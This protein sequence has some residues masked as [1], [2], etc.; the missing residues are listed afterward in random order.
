MVSRWKQ[1]GSARGGGEGGARGSLCSFEKSWNFILRCGW[2][3]PPT[4]GGGRDLP[5][6]RTAKGSQ[7]GEGSRCP[8]AGSGLANMSIT[9]ITIIVVAWGGQGHLVLMLVTG[10][11]ISHEKRSYPCHQPPC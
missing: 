3:G 5:K 6:L 2:I 11:P 10:N 1:A 7:G 4:T 8:E 9:A